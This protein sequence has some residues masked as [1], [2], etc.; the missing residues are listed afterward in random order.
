MNS[1]SLLHD[2]AETIPYVQGKS[3]P[4]LQAIVSKERG[5]FR[6]TQPRLLTQ[7]INLDE[8]AKKDFPTSSR[9]DYIVEYDGKV[10]FVEIHPANTRDVPVVL[11]KLDW[12]QKWLN[13]DG[14]A[15]KKLA[16]PHSFH[17]VATRKYAIL[18]DSKQ[19]KQLALRG[20]LPKST[21]NI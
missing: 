5:Y 18:K 4:G 10:H 20:L 3:K 19:Y 11:K 6:P 9:W 21:W 15:I 12:L 1:M 2:A 7:S 14:R 8:C 17:W 13:N 16:A